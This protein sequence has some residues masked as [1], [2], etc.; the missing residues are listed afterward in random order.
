MKQTQFFRIFVQRNNYIRKVATLEKMDLRTCL[1]FILFLVALSRLMC[2]GNAAPASSKNA[3]RKM[4]T[5]HRQENST[6]SNSSLP[7][8]DVVDEEGSSEEGTDEE[9]EESSESSTTESS[10]SGDSGVNDGNA[11]FEQ[12]EA[13]ADIPM[14]GLN[15][16]KF[17]GAVLEFSY[18]R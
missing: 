9:T 12:V 8:S 3:T 7:A 1:S 4:K 18:C 6:N 11:E 15:F 13:A 17:S 10:S 2:T 16:L 14:G 5:H